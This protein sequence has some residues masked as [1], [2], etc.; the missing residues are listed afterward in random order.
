MKM[1]L[2]THYRNW[3]IL[4]NNLSDVTIFTLLKHFKTATIILK[5]SAIK[6]QQIT[7]LPANQLQIDTKIPLI[8]QQLEQLRQLDTHM[9]VWTDPDYP[10]RLRH[11]TR[12]PP[13]L[14]VR[15]NNALLSQPQLA[16]VGSRKPTIN[17]IKTAQHLAAEVARSGFVITSGLALG[18]DKAS[19]EGALIAKK[20]TIAILGSGIDVLYPRAHSAL[21]QNIIDQ[22]GAIISEFLPGTPPRSAHF[23]QRN[24]IISGLS[25]GTLIVEAALKSGS[26]ITARYAL[27]QNRDVFAVPGSIHS[28]VSAGCHQLLKQGAKLVETVQDILEEY[29]HC[30]RLPADS[31]TA[32]HSDERSTT[33]TMPTDISPEDHTILGYL[34]FATATPPDS[35][36]EYTQLTAE[37]VN[38]R[39]MMLELAGYI[40]TVSGGYLRIK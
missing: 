21:A 17:G 30:K 37:Q 32:Y 3:L 10:I 13:V 14:F 33:H 7:G 19:H 38:T 27:E 24:R 25:M 16:I 4:L 9:C 31:N 34:T 12:P 20:P 18:I 40:I 29:S 6:R 35:I 15:G 5:T 11:I 23:P 28:P 2:T 39:L 22:K 8:E 36:I 1:T 26:L